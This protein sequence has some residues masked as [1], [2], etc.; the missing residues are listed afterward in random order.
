MND[1]QP[2]LSGVGWVERSEPHQGSRRVLAVGL[3]ALDPPYLLA[4]AAAVLLAV[5]AGCHA[6]S[7][8]QTQV[9]SAG[10]SPVAVAQ[11][12]RKA[13][14]RESMQ[15]GQIEAFEQTPL[16][17]KLPS[18]VEKLYVDIGDH[19]AAEQLLVELF[20][21]ELKEELR[22]KEAAVLQSRAEIE[23]A[24][25]A[26]RAAEAAVAAAEA[27]VRL[28]EAGS[29]RA[30]ADVARWQ[31]QFLRIS[32][33]V[34]GGS[35][36]RRL[37]DETRD[38][39]KAAEAAQG[40]VRAKVEAAKAA[41]S[42]SQADLAKAKAQEAV[43]TARQ[44]NAQADLARTKALVQ[45]TQLRAPYAGVVTERNVNRGDFVQPANSAAAKP[46]LAVARTDIVRIFV[47][48]PEM[49]SPW[50]EA[51]WP[52]Y[53]SVQALPERRVEGKVTRTSWVLGPNRTLRT[54]LDF[55]NPSGLLRPG[56]YATAHIV[57]QERPDALVLPLSAIVRQGQQA[58]CWV[59]EDGQ[60]KRTPITLG[61][62]AGNDVE[63][64]SGLKGGE[65][66]VQSPTAG[67]QD[68]QLVETS[69][70]KAHP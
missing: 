27:N 66:I 18:Y 39:L 55:P 29:I 53:V 3:A 64:V 46:L 7:S 21:P 13:I 69:H 1:L 8:A 62:Q 16:L 70:A 35:L 28:A 11:P 49:D 31:S 24:A 65:L 32:Q 59:V 58:S 45:Y 50:V 40:E 44:E 2:V 36:D 25:A 54:E 12:V 56:M 33:L 22:Q 57:L 34:A 30:A 15:P 42:Q 6:S 47:D 60:A 5:A 63:V 4:V 14:R 51:G 67:L 17:A 37:E 23:L 48:V 38:S 41:L 10:A 9:A 20:L 52:G 19:V 68:G 26:V 61:I 43:A